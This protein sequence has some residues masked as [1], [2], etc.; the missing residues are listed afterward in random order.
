MS[1]CKH[2]LQYTTSASGSDSN[3]SLFVAFHLVFQEDVISVQDI[4]C[5]DAVDAMLS[6][7]R[8]VVLIPVEL[9]ILFHSVI[10]YIKRTYT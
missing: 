4:F 8:F 10:V 9:T 5:I 7:M 2:D 6:E 3:P 1:D